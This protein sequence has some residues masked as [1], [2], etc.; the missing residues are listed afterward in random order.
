MLFLML[1]VGGPVCADF[2]FSPQLT[3]AGTPYPNPN[4]TVSNLVI[5]PDRKLLVAG[6]FNRANGLIRNGFARL[7]PNGS[8]D[9]TFVPALPES[10][11]V[12]VYSILL[13]NDGKI[14]VSGY[15]GYSGGVT[16]YLMRLNTD[17]SEDSSF[18]PSTGTS[19]AGFAAL[20]SDGK[21]IITG[22]FTTVNGID[23][24]KMARLNADGSL[25]TSYNPNPG[26]GVGLVVIQPDDK[27]IVSGQFSTMNGVPCATT[28]RLNVDG[29]LDTGFT[30]S[31]SVAFVCGAICPN[32]QILLG[33]ADE[34]ANNYLP[35]PRLFNSDGSS[36]SFS[37]GFPLQVPFDTPQPYSAYNLTLLSDGT[38]YYGGYFPQEEYGN[39]FGYARV[40]FGGYEPKGF[41]GY[42]TNGPPYYLGFAVQDD[43]RLYAYGPVYNKGLIRELPLTEPV[44]SLRV[45][46]G[47]TRIVWARSG[48]LQE[49]FSLSFDL[50]TD[51]GTTWTH[52]GGGE[53]D[54]VEGWQ[55]E[56]ITL[57]SSGL[58]RAR[59]VVMGGPQGMNRSIQELVSNINPEVRV[60]GSYEPYVGGSS[61]EIS[62]G[63]TTPAALDDTDFGALTHYDT[64]H[65]GRNINTFSIQNKGAQDLVLNGVSVTGPHASEFA[66][67]G[68][69]SG[70]QTL[71]PG[72]LVSFTITFDPVAVGLRTATVT[73]SSDD[74][75]NGSFDFAIQGVGGEPT[76]SI[77]G[78][79]TAITSGDTT[80]STGDFTDFGTATPGVT[81]QRTF[82]VHNTGTGSLILGSS[83]VSPPSGGGEYG[84]HQNI[85]YYGREIPPGGSVNF[86]I[87]FTPP[88]AGVT[89]RTFSI[90]SNAPS[91][92]LFSFDVMGYAASQIVVKG[93]NIVIPNGDMI[94]STADNTNLGTP[95]SGWLYKYFILHNTGAAP[96]RVTQLQGISGQVGDFGLSHLALPFTIAPGAST[97]LGVGFYPTSVGVKQTTVRLV[98][99]SLN[100][101]VYTFAMEA[102]SNTYFYVTGN[103]SYIANGD[104]TPTP[105]DNTFF[106]SV[107]WE[108]PKKLLY[109]I[110]NS[111]HVSLTVN[112][113]YLT[114]ANVEDFSVGGIEL[115]L[116]VPP[117]SSATFAVSFTPKAVGARYATLNVVSNTA[118]N[119]NATG[120]GVSFSLAGAGV[121]SWEVPSAEVVYTRDSVV[122]FVADLPVELGYAAPAF[123]LK[124]TPNTGAQLMVIRNNTQALTI[125]HYTGL[126]QG[127]P[128]ALNYQG[129]TYQFVIDYYG[130]DGNDVVLH[131]AGT[132]PY[133]WGINTLGQTGDGTTTSPRASAVATGYSGVLAGKTV[134]R[135]SSGGGHTLALTADGKIYAWG[136]NNYGQLGDNSI[137][138]RFSPVAVNALPG[139]ALYNKTVVA[140]AAGYV[141]SLALCSD[142]TVASWGYNTTGQLGTGV[143][144]STPTKIP[145]AVNTGTSSALNNKS[146]VRVVTS[147]SAWHSLALC[148]DGTLVS[149]GRNTSRCLGTT[150]TANSA[151]PVLVN[152]TSGALV[153]KRVLQMATGLDFSLAVCSDNSVAGW[154][155]NGSYQLGSGA[156]TTP[157]AVPI[158]TKISPLMTGG[159]TLKAIEAG[160]LHALALRSDGVVMS[161]GSNS[162]GQLGINK[163]ATTTASSPV[164]VLVERDY[165]SALTDQ[166]RVIAIEAGQNQSFAVCTDGTFVSWGQNDVGQLGAGATP[167]TRIYPAEISAGAVTE[168]QKHVTVAA[169]LDHTQSLVARPQGFIAVEQP[170]N[171][172]LADESSVVDFGTVFYTAGITMDSALRTKTFTLRNTGTGELGDLAITI[173]GVAAANYA[174]SAIT[175]PS[176][177]V[178]PV[179]GTAT[180]TVTF[181]PSAAGARAAALHIFSN[182]LGTNLP[183]DIA[184]TGVGSIAQL[185]AR[186]FTGAEIPITAATFTATGK[187]LDWNLNYAPTPGTVLTVV[188]NTGTAAIV[189]TFASLPAGEV[190]TYVLNDVTYEFYVNY[191][192]GTGND[193][194]LTLLPF[195]AESDFDGDGVANIQEYRDGT[196]LWNYRSYL[197]PVVWELH[198]N[199]T[200]LGGGTGGIQKTAGAAGLNADAVGTHKLIGDGKVSFRGIEVNSS[201]V[202]GF[203]QTDPTNGRDIDFSISTLTNGTAQVYEG[204][205]AITGTGLLGSFNVGTVFTIERKGA[206][207]RYYKDGV[208]KHTSTKFCFGPMLVDCS[209]NTLNHSISFVRMSGDDRDDDEIPDS[210]EAVQLQKTWGYNPAPWDAL[211]G[212]FIPGDDTDLDGIS[213]ANEYAMGTNPLQALNKPQAVSWGNFINTSIVVG[214][215]GGLKKNSG[216]AAGY[217]SDAFSTQF[218]D[219]SGSFSFK[220]APAGTLDVGVTYQNNSRLNTDLEYS[221]VLTAATASIRRPEGAVIPVGPYTAETV[222]T[223]RR[224]GTQLQYLVDGLL[225][226]TSSTT[227]TGNLYADC[228]ISTANHQI[229]SAWFV[230]TDLDDDGLPDEWELRY[231]PLNAVLLN[232]QGLLPGDISPDGDGLSYLVEYQNGSSPNSWDTDEDGIS[233][234]WEIAHGQSP[235]DSNNSLADPDNDGLNNLGEFNADS[236]PLLAD[237]DGDGVAD[238]YEVQHGFQVLVDDALADQDDDGIPNLWEFAR[239]TSSSDAESIPTWDAIVD[240]MLDVLQRGNQYRNLSAAYGALPTTAGYRATILLKRAIHS[241]AYIP[242]SEATR[243]VA[244]VSVGGANRAEGQEGAIIQDASWSLKGDF[245][246]KGLIFESGDTEGVVLQPASGA[247]GR[248]VNCLF[249]NS[250]HWRDHTSSFYTY[251]GAITN[252]GAVMEVEHCTF[253]NCNIYTGSYPYTGLASL[254]NQSGSLKVKNS[255]VWDQQ[256]VSSSAISGSGVTVVNSLIQGGTGG[257]LN[258]DPELTKA[259]YLKAGSLH[260]FTAG[261][262]TLVAK[263]IH[264]Q[265]RSLSTPGLGA[266]QWSNS[267][268]DSLPSWWEQWLFGHSTH[269]DASMIDGHWQP[270]LDH[271]KNGT[272]PVKDHD[273]DGLLDTWERSRFNPNYVTTPPLGL[274]DGDD[275]PDMDTW[276]NFAEC[277]WSLSP[278]NLQFDPLVKNAD[279]DKD[280]LPDI[281]EIYHWGDLRWQTGSGDADADGVFNAAEFHAGTDPKYAPGDADKDG[282]LDADEAAWFGGLS[283]KGSDDFDG[284]GLSNYYEI[285]ISGT[286]PSNSDSN[287]D[288]YLDGFL[289]LITSQDADGD[290]LL[291]ADEVA[292]GTDPHLADTD[293]DGV[294]DSTDFFP[295]NAMLHLRIQPNPL[296]TTPPVLTLDEPLDAQLLPLP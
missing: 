221:F 206:Q 83:G 58:I 94:T 239:N 128:V 195:L 202:V 214:S 105:T 14:L 162:F 107:V 156:N 145:T 246:L 135:I 209:I 70:P 65:S 59:A 291:S 115:P 191:N 293:G 150:T 203:N 2:T 48:D 7:N 51:A 160:D 37:S 173:D 120:N 1:T 223:I 257:A 198:A 46:D 262:A 171:T 126:P 172:V 208:L 271:Y 272:H 61:V 26:S 168:L 39:N 99:D 130:G 197:S 200:S 89:Q 189:G 263:D 75:V 218:I 38:F 232:L 87:Y 71:S 35:Q 220:V 5:Q 230:D 207:V 43:G 18:A 280:G 114:G 234:S 241:N 278:H 80:P 19:Y 53:F 124:F 98:S 44:Q 15:L 92:P 295:V 153:G 155:A 147:G 148:S 45:V 194:T 102:N 21:I 22:N 268:G 57:P 266:V 137:M 265:S 125:G 52:L 127:S 165:P 229:S 296:D 240:P 242:S 118:S 159:W 283:Q 140:V 20:Q 47:G 69:T 249:R 133:G 146:V 226:Y 211:F 294:P 179:G 33:E 112:S 276:S 183:F 264:G 97:S 210:W 116:S 3:I 8:V 31:S 131:W 259:G 113:V 49:I 279:A 222:F 56:G 187:T 256:Y 10:S 169:G 286:D 292:A 50:S 12:T 143:A 163:L 205:T 54:T 193:L 236:N 103:G 4:S 212:S 290:G 151:F 117:S 91:T 247:R 36:A 244:I 185:E 250:Q 139:S 186:F 157:V 84:F 161:W 63:D 281:W 154:G 245:F 95:S 109:K 275:D 252:Q 138:D 129:K 123:S 29:T 34:L 72:Q 132:R 238:G 184:L 284:D 9:T 287:G 261:A 27:L 235:T 30:L 17:G 227:S 254:A 253:L 149:W 188:N 176:G 285:W 225:I 277:V 267:D 86:T 228:S 142:G 40:Y 180:F 260:C 237:T 88:A 6:S 152:T 182:T 121:S 74:P 60:S 78:N 32:G 248:M 68:I 96:L 216:V 62:K 76:I 122:P 213:N 28:V 23:R 175:Y 24:N 170:V 93:N 110:H 166:K 196:D 258:V 108:T 199:T 274:Y 282:I 41:F 224:M 158:A 167:T 141:H 144:S 90:A 181:S 134:V 192:G 16:R 269:G 66:L 73:V 11:F 100:D 55:I 255:I 174:V 177:S 201:T 136:D 77:T 64:S 81:V 217:N 204:A 178:I 82:V 111:G 13:Q 270:L 289:G 104:T 288:G 119:S 215:Q 190:V 164:P 251:G 101:G 273:G 106:G 85:L 243:N 67:A 219:G 25:D 233:D 42:S 231:L 79:G